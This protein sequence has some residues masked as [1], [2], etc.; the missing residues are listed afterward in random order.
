MVL[1]YWVVFGQV[2]VCLSPYFSTF[3][4]F[5]EHCTLAAA[6]EP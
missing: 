1:E 6:Q 3:I 4:L 5:S 2:V